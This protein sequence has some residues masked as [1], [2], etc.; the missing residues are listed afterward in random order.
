MNSSTDSSS[1]TTCPDP[2]Q[3]AAAQ[4]R[5][6]PGKDWTSTDCLQLV[7]APIRFTRADWP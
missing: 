3:E 2:Q 4:P 7:R 6:I 1:E 5:E